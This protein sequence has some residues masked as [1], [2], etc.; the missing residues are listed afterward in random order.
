MSTVTDDYEQALWDNSFY[1]SAAAITQLSSS[2]HIHNLKRAVNIPNSE[3]SQLIAAGL[4][5][6]DVSNGLKANE[7]T[8]TSSQK[9]TLLM[10]IS[11][12]M[13]AL[14][15]AL[16]SD[17]PRRIAPEVI[18]EENESPESSM[19]TKN[20][21]AEV[22]IQESQSATLYNN[23]SSESV[24]S[25]ESET[26]IR[27]NDFQPLM[28]VDAIK[29]H[30]AYTVP[31]RKDLSTP[32]LETVAKIER[33]RSQR[34]QETKRLSKVRNSASDLQD[35]VEYSR[36]SSKKLTR[37]IQKPKDQLLDEPFVPKTIRRPVKSML[38]AVDPAP[39]LSS[40]KDSNP[41]SRGMSHGSTSG[42]SSKS[43]SV[44]GTPKT[45]AKL[46]EQPRKSAPP[47]AKRSATT[48]DISKLAKSP[49][50]DT[51][52]RTNSKRFSFRG[53]FKLKSKPH[54]L[55]N[56]TEDA[57]SEPKVAEEQSSSTPKIQEKTRLELK[58]SKTGPAD[59]F[60]GIFRRRKS[61]SSMDFLSEDAPQT[62][63]KSATDGALS[64]RSKPLPEIHHN[65]KRRLPKLP[66]PSTHEI[67]QVPS[68]QPSEG[69]A[70]MDTPATA[71]LSPETNTIR[72]VDDSDYLL[73]VSQSVHDQKL[74]GWEPEVSMK[75]GHLENGEYDEDAGDFAAD[76]TADLHNM[77]LME[78]SE[79]A[80]GSPF[81]V[82][83]P[84]EDLRRFSLPGPL[85]ELLSE[86]GY[87]SRRSSQR[88]SA[89]VKEQLV[90]EALFPKSL[91]PH[92]V[93]S[94]VSLERSISMRS[95]RSNGKRSSYLNYSGSDGNV[96]LGSEVGLVR[97][98]LMKRSGSILKN[99]P[100]S[101]SLRAEVLN[102][103]DATLNTGIAEDSTENFA[104]M[105]LRKDETHDTVS[106]TS[107]QENYS[108][109]IEFSD[110]IDFDNL[111]FGA[112][113][114]LL[115]SGAFSVDLEG[116]STEPVYVN[117]VSAIDL[118]DEVQMYGEGERIDVNEE[119]LH[120][121]Q[122]SSHK[123]HEPEH[124]DPE[125]IAVNS[126]TERDCSQ[127][128]DM[129][130]L[131]YPE[132]RTVEDPVQPYEYAYGIGMNEVKQRESPN[133]ASRPFS[134]SFKGFNGTLNKSKVVGKHGLH[135]LLQD[136]NES[137]NESSIESSV[138]GQ[139]FGSSDEEFS[140]DDREVT[141]DYLQTYELSPEMTKESPKPTQERQKPATTSAERRQQHLKN[142]LQ[143]Q[144]PL[145][146]LPFHHDR[147]PSI[148]DQSATS[149]PR[150][151][152]SFMGRL[153]KPPSPQQTKRRV[154]FSSRIILY[155]TYHPDE[156]DR[157]PDIAT[158]NQLTPLLAQQIRDELNEFK[159]AMEVHA[160]SRDNTY[161][162]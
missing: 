141:D 79:E 106:I 162:F 15:S 44:F 33:E 12:S 137:S 148:S 90:G 126:S 105:T 4:L 153:R 120:E 56:I 77:S 95:L 20:L 22:V 134:M 24:H 142:V 121:I 42:L 3:L 138:V 5:E 93:E 83:L 26:T 57:R 84:M 41:L 34:E 23:A 113:S 150:L 100:S 160:N 130:E 129:V 124:D 122:I 75:S 88:V 13:R 16:N 27:D 85:I 53:L 132:T 72:E 147:I 140:D 98:G 1:S 67:A 71:F 103:I 73:N 139:G 21:P 74:K 107:S 19:T 92:E 30:D 63:T 65:E 39:A 58:E 50:T 46:P 11:P 6:T 76:L 9:R 123:E 18:M 81:L 64:L 155:D 62:M 146:T 86:P 69:L 47:V 149:S 128:P 108:Q 135:Q 144:P 114:D 66:E 29:S 40:A 136:C 78:E 143:L 115:G 159:A 38:D 8:P 131:S 48:G 31:I 152:T 87:Q 49:L 45:P 104:D 59:N 117:S 14:E 37:S 151:L 36:T 158:C 145:Q 109:L 116:T 51:T 101:K 80:F 10:R 70:C 60:K 99:S 54:S 25:G 94:I 91:N 157:H 125:V 96:L 55:T 7:T 43:S 111:D 133:L 61:Q 17:G 82:P 127:L 2:N 68:P 89:P 154:S 110:F 97:L 161:F 102:L 118:I 156:Y 119:E 52:N 35:R 28:A 32:D 112:G